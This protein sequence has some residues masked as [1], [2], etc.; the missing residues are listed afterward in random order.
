[1]IFRTQIFSGILLFSALS[2]ALVYAADETQ[3]VEMQK[4]DRMLEYVPKILNTFVV[5]GNNLKEDPITVSVEGVNFCAIDPASVH[6][7]PFILPYTKL[8]DEVVIEAQADLR[9]IKYCYNVQAQALEKE[10]LLIYPRLCV[11]SNGKQSYIKLPNVGRMGRSTLNIFLSKQT[12][13]INADV[14]WTNLNLESI[15]PAEEIEVRPLHFLQFIADKKD[16]YNAN[17]LQKCA[18]HIDELDGDGKEIV[19]TG[20]MTF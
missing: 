14:H 1:M 3:K 13:E 8:S 9:K 11:T 4:I 18:Q 16:R 20:H 15:I 2:G 7:S 5:V 10:F 19:K 6:T 12:Q 17:F